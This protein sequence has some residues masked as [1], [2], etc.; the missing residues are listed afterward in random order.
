[1]FLVMKL[2]SKPKVLKCDICVSFMCS[3]KMTINICIL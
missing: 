1:M 2:F 3:A